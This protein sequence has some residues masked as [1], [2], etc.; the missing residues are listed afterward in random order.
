MHSGPHIKR[1]GLVF[2]YDTGYSGTG[3][4]LSMGRHFKGPASSTILEVLNHSISNTSGTTG[5]VLTEEEVVKIPKVGS[6][7][8]QYVE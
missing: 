5:F 1:D 8:V 7:T 6:R 2:G 3:K 4:N